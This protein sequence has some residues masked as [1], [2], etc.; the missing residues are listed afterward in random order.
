MAAVIT[1]HVTSTYIGYGSNILVMGMNLAFILNQLARFSVPLFILLSG[2]S[3]GL[4][5]SD[6]SFS[7]FLYKRFTKI[8]VPYLVWTAIYI[9]YK[10]PSALGTINFQSL[11]KT[12]LLGQA[13]PHLYFVVIIFQFYLLFPFLRR[14]INRAPYQSILFSFAVSYWIQKLFYF[15]RL[16]TDLIPGILQP[17]LWLL[18]PTWIFYFVAGTVLSEHRLTLIRKFASQNTV[19]ILLVTLLF[20]GLYVMESHVTG[21]IESIKTSLNLY[22]ILVLLGFER[23]TFFSSNSLHNKDTGYFSNNSA[24]SSR[25]YSIG[26]SLAL[27]SANTPITA[28]KAQIITSSFLDFIYFTPI[29]FHQTLSCKPQAVYIKAT[30]D[31]LFNFSRIF[32]DILSILLVKRHLEHT[33]P[34]ARKS[35]LTRSCRR[36]GTAA[37][38]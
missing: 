31:C 32:T 15:R 18:F 20:S 33:K 8:G 25:E 24:N 21:S 9:I 10:N 1:I 28:A 13:A 22:V 3:L 27:T 6:D 5:A 34:R 14:Y 17:Y 38:V 7:G 29:L 4:S 2:A 26:F 19:A 35:T 30:Y 16:G 11:L 36:I 37:Q 23:I 12:V